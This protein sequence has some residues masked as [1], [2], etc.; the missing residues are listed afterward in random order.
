MGVLAQVRSQLTL[1]FLSSGFAD[2]AMES[3]PAG[4]IVMILLLL[5]IPS[6]FP[7]HG[8]P[9]YVPRKARQLVSKITTTRLDSLGTFL[10]LSASLLLVTGLQIVGLKYAWDSAAVLSLLII[11][12]PLWPAFLCWEWYISRQTS[13]T[14][15]VLPF[16]FIKNR[17]WIA[18]IL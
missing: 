15:P 11:S 6:G 16:R 5:T 17:I 1:P 8:Q 7:H 2:M 9:S 3:V 4:V 12:V 13:S 10:L 14:E 18:M